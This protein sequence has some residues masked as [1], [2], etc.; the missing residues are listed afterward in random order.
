VSEKGEA[1]GKRNAC[2]GHPG[3]TEMYKYEW[4]GEEAGTLEY[5]SYQKIDK[6]VKKGKVAISTDEP[7]SGNYKILKIINFLPAEHR[8]IAGYDWFTRN[9]YN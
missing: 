5:V 6:N 7:Y 3:E 9:G 2:N 1:V 8:K 4:N